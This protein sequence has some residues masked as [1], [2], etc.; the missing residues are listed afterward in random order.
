MSRDGDEGG[1]LQ[2]WYLNIG[3]SEVRLNF[4]LIT[5]CIYITDHSYFN[6]T[7][8]HNNN[9]D[10]LC[11]LL[12]LEGNSSYDFAVGRGLFGI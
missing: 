10:V 1:N 3:H 7:Q 8:W 12:Y 6:S 11:N 9:N 4:R 2:A 5:Y